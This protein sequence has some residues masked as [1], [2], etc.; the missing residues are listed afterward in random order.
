MSPPQPARPGAPGFASCGCLGTGA[1]L[2]VL[3]VALKL[4]GVV[5]WSWWLVLAPVWVTLAGAI[6][7][8]TL[9][10]VL[11]VAIAASEDDRP[12]RAAR[13]SQHGPVHRWGRRG[14]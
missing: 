14:P 2:L 5:D 4:T 13:P 7:I 3:F 12:D 11:L 1:A 6:L 10:F 9:G 8:L